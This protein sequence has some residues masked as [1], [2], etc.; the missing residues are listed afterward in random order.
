MAVHHIKIGFFAKCIV[1]TAPVGMQSLA[2]CRSKDSSTA[3]SKQASQPT[4]ADDARRRFGNAKSIS[5]SM[6]D[7]DA[8]KPN[9]YE[10]QAMLS[11]FSVSQPNMSS[12][13]TEVSCETYG[14]QLM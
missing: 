6:F 7:E 2:E 4:E 3:L 9:D 13:R 14:Q 5:S 11:K 12:T 8:N 10:K 1:Q